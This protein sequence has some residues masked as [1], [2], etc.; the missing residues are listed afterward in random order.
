MD[1]A[2]PEKFIKPSELKEKTGNKMIKL[3]KNFKN[4]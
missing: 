1:N 3:K 2:L 4:F